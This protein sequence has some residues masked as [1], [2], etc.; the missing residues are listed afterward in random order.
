[1]FPSITEYP[2]KSGSLHIFF[3]K[4]D[5]KGI[6]DTLSESNSET[7]LKLF[8]SKAKFTD[9]MRAIS[10]S[11]GLSKKVALELIEQGGYPYARGIIDN[12]Q[13]FSLLDSEVALMMIEKGIGIL[14]IEHL[15][16]F[17]NISKEFI[18]SLFLLPHGVCCE[19]LLVRF[20]FR[21][22]KY[23]ALALIKNR[24]SG[25]DHV[26]CLFDKF[27]W[28]DKDVANALSK[29]GHRQWVY[30]NLNRFYLSVNEYSDFIATYVAEMLTLSIG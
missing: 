18:N 24:N 15:H 14:V 28:L 30:K 5:I 26:L 3:A 9:V 25:A 23:I 11:T 22:H 17:H 19:D 16:I 8:H 6:P 1:M 2:V 7:I 27:H 10:G 4:D 12:F 29:K 21:V 20:P 13:S